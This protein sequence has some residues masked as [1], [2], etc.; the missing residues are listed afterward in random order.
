MPAA[1][2]WRNLA[3]LTAVSYVRCDG[4]PCRYFAPS[5]RHGN[6]AEK[7]AGQS[8]NSTS[9]NEGAAWNLNSVVALYTVAFKDTAVISR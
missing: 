8:T 1:G 9:T 3:N 2:A 5:M 6:E 4:P 7:R